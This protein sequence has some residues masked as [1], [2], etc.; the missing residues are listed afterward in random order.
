ME[1]NPIENPRVLVS[2]AAQGPP[3]TVA[4]FGLGSVTLVSSFTI[5][6]SGGV[7]VSP[8][9]GNFLNNGDFIYGNINGIEGTLSRADNVY[10]FSRQTPGTAVPVTGGVASFYPLR[11]N[12]IIFCTDTITTLRNRPAVTTDEKVFVGGRANTNDEQWAIYRA[13]PTDNTSSDDGALIIVSSGGTRWKRIAAGSNGLSIASALTLGGVKIGT[14]IPITGDGTI[15]SYKY[16]NR[17]YVSPMG[18]DTNDGRSPETSLRTIKTAARLAASTPTVESIYVATGEYIEDNPVYLPPGTAVIGDNLRRTIVKPLNEGRDFFWWSSGCYINYLV[19]QDYYFGG[20][21]LLDTSSQA[22]D[23]EFPATGL[24]FKLFPGHT[25]QRVPGVYKDGAGLISFQRVSIINGAYDFMISLNPDLVIPDGGQAWKTDIGYIVDAVAN[26]LKAGGNVNAI[27][28]GT[29]YRDING[30]LISGINAAK[31]LQIK[32]AFNK[33]RELCK[34]AIMN[35]PPNYGTIDTCNPGAC[36][37]VSNTIDS[38]FDIA[39]FI[40]DGGD[41]PPY[42]SGSSYILIDQEWIEVFDITGDTITIANTGKRGVNNPVTGANSTAAKHINGAVV[43]QAGR[44]FRY[45][46][47]FPDQSGYIGKGRISIS[48]VAVIGTGTKFTTECFPNWQLKVGNTSYTIQSIL[49]DTS[50][51]LKEIGTAQADKTYKIIPKKEQIFLSPYIQNCSNISVLGN[52]YYDDSIK[53]Y[54]A[55]KT[56]AGGML[57]DNLQLDNKTPVPS[58]VSDA[59]TQVAF[60]GIGFHLKNDAYAQLVSVFQVFSGVGVLTES[61]GYA[62]ITN[63]ATNFG[64]IG[65]VA[66]GFSNKA[67]PSFRDATVTFIENATKPGF[68]TTPTNILSSSFASDSGGLKTK[69]TIT[70]SATDISKFEAGQTIAI[71]GHTSTPTINGANTTISGVNF[72][73]NSIE[74]ILNIAYP[75]TQ[76]N[77]AATGNITITSGKLE[78]KVTV[79]GF[80][81]NP[82]ANYIVKIT[83]L[84]SHPS[85][86]EY[87]VNEIKSELLG[88]VCTFTLGQVIPASVLATLA[89]NRPIE[90]RA[91]STINSSS[92][93]F[94]YVG[95]G[96]NYTAL[97]INGGRT[98]K[99]KQ[100]IEIN[101]GKCYVSATDQDGNFSVGTYF[102]VNLRSGQITF[103]GQLNLGVIDAL[104]LRGSPGIPI[105]EFVTAIRSQINAK[106]TA[107]PTE[108]AVRD[109]VVSALGSLFNKEPTTSG[110]TSAFGGQ[111]VQLTSEGIVDPSMVRIPISN[112]FTVA[113]EAARLVVSISGVALKAGDYVVQL[114]PAPAAKYIL[115][116]LPATNAA[117]WDLFSTDSFDASAIVSGRI[118]PARIANGTANDNTFASGGGNWLPTVQNLKPGSNSPIQIGTQSGTTPVSGGQAGF[119]EIDIAKAA[120]TTGQ[121]TGSSTIGVAA[122]N[123]DDF[124]ISNSIISIRDRLKSASSPLSFDATTGIL[125]IPR[126]TSIQSGFLAAADWILFN[127]LSSRGNHVGTQLASTI[128]DFG[129]SVDARITLQ[130]GVVNGIASLDASGQIPSS[131]IPAIAVTNTFVVASQAAMLALTVQPG[132]IAV[133]TDLNKTFILASTPATTLSN[134][135][136]IL[137]PLDS[138]SSVNGLSGVVTLVASDVGAYTTA[139]V[140]TLLAG[141]LS[142]IA[143]ASITTAKIADASITS[144]KIADAS[145]TSAKIADASI[146][147]AKIA[148]NA[149][150][151]AKIAGASIALANPSHITN[152]DFKITQATTTPTTGVSVTAGNAVPTASL[153]YPVFDCW[154]AYCLGTNGTL[155]QVAQTATAPARLQLATLANSTGAG[156]GQRI[157]SL[158]SINLANKTVTLSFSCSHTN[159]T[160]LTV[161]AN[162]P[163]TNADVFGTIGTPTKTQV[164]ATIISINSTLTRYTWTFTCTAD[165]D[166]GLEILFTLGSNASAGTF[167]LANVKLEEGSSATAFIPTDYR[168]ELVKCQRYFRLLSNYFYGY[169]S[170]AN[171]TISTEVLHLGMFGSSRVRNIISESRNGAF[172]GLTNGINADATRVNYTISGVSAP[173][174]V[175][176]NPIFTVSA[177]IP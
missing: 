80:K 90:L 149:V 1:V 105:Y 20:Q 42:N 163:T 135:V 82:L 36:T 122:F 38:L 9:S 68:N 19:F 107:I 98:D 133:R 111:L 60:G 134:W 17:I 50:I 79:N 52:S 164:A 70:V 74:V 173:A 150:T 44:A 157:E 26:D 118:S 25:L 104:E 34:A 141:K 49:T 155:S 47:A 128:S 140:N 112:I 77:G 22:N 125:S 73:G 165:V 63:S 162:R 161:T 94:E 168:T 40:L 123:Y 175:G 35:V 110:G 2:P 176:A 143:D 67:M 177:Y 130:K 21:G 71:A 137:A 108:K 103:A 85:G 120:F 117:N 8:S 81:Q 62:S 102:N 45:A 48:G 14:G 5:P 27:K 158:N 126:A 69:A 88:G 156:V 86:I 29:A 4:E 92:H 146:T 3:G 64:D 16:S 12:Q 129:T 78:T 66:A 33:A 121:T 114:S 93:T 89:A 65:L 138:V 136:E 72:S 116:A 154:F 39:I 169:Y 18:S 7:V 119:I 115:K 151:T 84:P 113:N 174:N 58:N 51:T 167:V 159:L 109:W 24:T 28:T 15:S 106:N 153:G 55:D 83:D 99:S 23:R 142:S 139:Q 147:S 160:S 96:T 46:V 54:D 61:G 91:P 132:D 166:K 32:Q 144:A 43:S 172:V 97:P 41:I 145:I 127:S 6:P 131:Q 75:N 10:T 59:F 171:G 100:A 57:V 124:L 95:A 31:V 13:D 56:R 152:S 148:D 53:A 37:Q 101:G 87:T 11:S 30:E 76:I 170:S